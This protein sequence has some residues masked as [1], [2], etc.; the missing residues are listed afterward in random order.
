MVIGPLH[1][2]ELDR[3][4][5]ECDGRGG[6]MDAGLRDDLRN[7]ELRF[8]AKVDATL[9]P[10]SD[11]YYHQQVGLYR[12]IA[13]REVDQSVGEMTPLTLEAHTDS[14]NPYGSNNVRYVARHARTIQACLLVADLP[15]GAHI[16]DLGCGWGLSS[17]QMAFSGARVTAVDI[18]PDFVELV[19][20]RAE[21]RRLPIEA[22]C[23]DFDHYEDSRQYDMVFYYECL[24]H[25]LKP[26]ETLTRAAQWVRPGGKIVCAGEPVNDRWWPGWGLRLDAESVYCI[27]KFG[28]WE[29]GWS[30]GFLSQCFAR[31]GFTLT[32]IPDLGLDD[33]P[34][35]FAV[36]HNDANRI[37][38]DL[39]L[40]GPQLEYH[41]CHRA[42]ADARNRIDAMQASLSW[43]LAAPVRTLGRW[44]RRGT[45][46]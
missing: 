25:A 27:R 1:T 44:M 3:F 12:E 8:D 37:K 2:S 30:A 7:F 24:H 34:I 38:P 19:R 14:P 5:R 6:L 28:W 42:L 16:L 9:D 26:W 43:R 18:N 22:V 35:G 32:L 41:A 40:R 4:V 33:S 45:A 31:A 10:F 11:E 17:E 13:G 23:S 36:R 29:S 15:A 20:R 46:K 39:T 21:P